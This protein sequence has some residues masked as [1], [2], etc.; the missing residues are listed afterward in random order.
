MKCIM[1]KLVVAFL[2]FAVK[3]GFSQTAV[4]NTG[5]LYVNGS[6]DILYAGSDFTNNCRIGTYQ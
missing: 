6:S 2:M 5:I 4:T 3:A 1:R